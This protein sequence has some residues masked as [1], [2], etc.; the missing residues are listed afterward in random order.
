MK[1]VFFIALLLIP[2]F[3]LVTIKPLHGQ[4]WTEPVNIS[5][6][7]GYS[8]EP[9]MII[10]HK[11]VIHVVWRY[12]ITGYH[13]LILYSYSEDDGLTWTE[14]LDLLQNTDLWMLQPHIACDSK[15]NL[16]VTYTHNGFEWPPEGRLIKML[17]YDGQQWSKPFIISKEMPGSHYNQLYIDYNDRVIVGWDLETTGDNYFRFFENNF[18]TDAFCPYPGGTE[19]YGFVEA[20][21]DKDNSLH[22]IGA[23]MGYAYPGQ[24]RLQYFYYNNYQNSWYPPFMPVKDTI[25]VGQDIALSNNKIPQSAYRKKSKVSVDAIWDSTMLIK[26]EGDLWGQP[27]LISGTG[28]RQEGQQIVVD[29]NNEVH[30][31]ETEFYASSVSETQLVHYS[32]NGNNWQEQVVDSSN[33]MCH[34]PKLIFNRNTLY[35]VYYK[36]EVSAIG[37]LRFSKYDIITNIKEEAKQTPELK[38]YPNPGSGI[39]SIEFENSSRQLVDL[40]VYDINGKL[41]SVLAHKMLPPGM[42]R[43]VWEAHST[44]GQKVKPGTYLV[45]LTAGDNTATQ[46]VEIVK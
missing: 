35:V 34:F 15:N 36:S 22:W 2:I 40:S 37:D 12:R 31:V 27:I 1:R 21:V 30:I 13:W 5:N 28:K 6:L 20:A 44:N 14:P 32:K 26:K 3:I 4:Q 38:I 25:G 16:Y 9:D 19:I 29:Q 45:K 43:F 7:G 41:V 10:D 39:I 11:G 42:Q 24:E 17:T 46:V 23:S 8:M 33:H 18:W